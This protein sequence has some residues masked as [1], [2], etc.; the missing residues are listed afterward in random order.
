MTNETGMDFSVVNKNLA[1]KLML[2]HVFIIGLANYIVQ[3][4]LEVFGFKATWAMFL[5]PLVLVATDLTTRLTN[6]YQ[7]RFVVGLAFIPA[8]VISALLSDW[9]IGVASALAY[10]IGQLFDVTIFQRVREAYKTWWI[11]PLI[12]GVFANVIDTYAFFGAAFYNSANEYMA[13]NWLA[14][15]NADVVFKTVISMVIILPIYGVLLNYLLGRVKQ[16]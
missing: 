13:A 7:A 3:F 2:V 5:F 15:A 1:I 16:D 4:P 6:K 9:R 10:L 14:I 8:A 11:A 12:S